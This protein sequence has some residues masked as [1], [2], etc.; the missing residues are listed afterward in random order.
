MFAILLLRTIR[1]DVSGSRF[2]ERGGHRAIAH[3]DDFVTDEKACQVVVLL[4]LVH[5]LV[6]GREL[7][8]V[9][10]GRLLLDLG[11]EKCRDPGITVIS[12]WKKRKGELQHLQGTNKCRRLRRSSCSCCGRCLRR[13]DTRELCSRRGSALASHRV[14]TGRRPRAGR[15]GSIGT[16]TPR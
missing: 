10:V 14:C 4:E 15:P 16:R 13:R 2:D 12:N 9:P 5:D 1:L 7:R 11:I 3:G 8:L 6:E